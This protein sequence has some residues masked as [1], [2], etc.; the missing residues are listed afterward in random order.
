[1]DEYQYYIHTYIPTYTENKIVQLLARSVILSVVSEW[2]KVVIVRYQC[3]AAC[4]GA[5]LP[6]T[7]RS[8]AAA[9]SD[10]SKVGNSLLSRY[11]VYSRRV[12]A[13]IETDQ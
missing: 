7:R 4:Y 12:D 11:S 3:V 2:S 10:N 13:A 1:M 8:H 9:A 6:G 5:T